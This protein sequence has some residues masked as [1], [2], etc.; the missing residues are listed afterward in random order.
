[1]IASRKLSST[2]KTSSSYD[3]KN[4]APATD[5]KPPRARSSVLTSMLPSR[6]TKQVLMDS[7]K[8]ENAWGKQVRGGSVGVQ[9]VSTGLPAWH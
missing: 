9:A 7:P 3:Q 8:V 5:C 1:M 6:M 4:R 2:M